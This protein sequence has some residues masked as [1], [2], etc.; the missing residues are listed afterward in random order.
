MTIPKIKQIK[1]ISHFLEPKE[2]LRLKIL[3]FIIL[4]GLF[5]L[6][7]R[8]YTV[9]LKILPAKGGEY[10]EALIGKLKYINPI[11]A[12][13]NEVDLDISRLIFS[14]LLRYDKNQK[15][16]PNLASQYE[17]SEDQK[18]YTFLLKKNVKWHDKGTFNADDVIFTIE[19]IQNPEFKSPLYSSFK[20]VKCEKI[21]DYQIKFVLDEPYSPFP[22]LLTMGIISKRLWQDISPSQFNLAEYN[23]KPIGTGP[24]KFKSLI[25][26]KRGVIKNYI[27]Q[28]NDDF[29]RESPFLEKFIFKFYADP[30]EAIEAFKNK[31]VSGLG[32]VAGILG[33]TK[34]NYKNFNDYSLRL[35]QYTSIFFN[36]ANNP[37][38]KEKNLRQALS[39]VIDKEKIIKE[40]LLEKGEIVD[41]PILPDSLGYNSDIKKY[42][43]DINKANQLLDASGWKFE[44]STSTNQEVKNETKFRKKGGEELKIILTTVEK[45]EN[46]KIVEIIKENW[47]KIG[48][49]TETQIIPR[50]KILK[51]IIK[52]RNYQALLYSV[53]LGPDADP[54]LLWHSSQISEFGLNLANFSNKEADLVLE[55]GRKISDPA[56][57][58]LK[59]QHFQ[60]IMLE[61]VPAIF[62]YSPSYIYLV[63]KK[64]KGFDLKN[65]SLPFERFS[66]AEEWYIKTKKGL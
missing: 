13:A 38:L 18:T 47:E 11:L 34:I 24:F 56:A 55:E 62:L 58:H 49:R 26:D 12:P 15:L 1:Y 46:I 52:P 23:L 43:L 17:I 28:R 19:T 51:E 57:R 25:K 22:S 66:Y 65:I 42:R 37:V 32:I 4:V 2:K 27:L 45:T 29:Y 39:Y 3:W 10:S 16:A 63:D 64:I 20:G 30:D 36:Q 31:G 50:E 40:V 53:I 35:P 60:N 59:Y 41:G 9:Y 8:F 7:V 6:G 54:Y 14:G 48:I 21:D 33:K 61:Q 44:N 5:F